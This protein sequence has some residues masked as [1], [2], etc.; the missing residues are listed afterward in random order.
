MNLYDEYF[1]PHL[2]HCA[3][4]L[5]AIDQQRAKMVPLAKGRV[6]EVGMGSGLN[7]KHYNADQVELVWGLEPSRGMRLKA[8]RNL[9][10][11]R[12]AVEWLDLPSESIPLGDNSADTVVLTYTLC[13]IDDY[14]GALAEMKRVLKPSGQ[15]VFSEHGQAPDAAVRKWQRRVNPIWKKLVGG[16]NLD[17]EIP[18]LIEEAGFTI[19][20]LQQKYIKGPKIATYQYFGVAVI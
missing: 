20:Q 5:K 8:Q 4:G 3:C 1:L 2:I 14:Q 7:L 9:D 13:T 10:Q 12:V 6:L 15:L 18:V 11:S 16:C 19:K 17:R